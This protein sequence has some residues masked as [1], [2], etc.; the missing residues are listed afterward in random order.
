VNLSDGST[1]K[2]V[3]PKGGMVRNEGNRSGIYTEIRYFP[4]WRH[5]S[6]RHNR[7]NKQIKSNLGITGPGIHTFIHHY[8][9]DLIG[10]I[11]R[12]DKEAEIIYQKINNWAE[13]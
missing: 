13:K 12:G 10:R 5:I 6:Q 9:H 7:I 11:I 3:I 8:L 4:P 2:Y 1:Y